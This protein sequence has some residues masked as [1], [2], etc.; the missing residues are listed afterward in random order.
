MN[1]NVNKIF[2]LTVP[3]YVYL[4][5]AIKMS[6]FSIAIG[7]S[8]QE[9]CVAHRLIPIW[10]LVFGIIGVFYLVI[11]ILKSTET[12]KDKWVL[13]FGRNLI[14]L[15]L[16]IWWICGKNLKIIRLNHN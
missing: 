15:F 6:F 8:N 12:Y 10:V 16:L 1:L 4:V 2:S 13:E 9:S 14:Y 7:I 5:T 3:A 11:T